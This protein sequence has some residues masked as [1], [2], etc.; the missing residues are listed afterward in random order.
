MGMSCIYSLG[1]LFAT[2]ADGVHTLANRLNGVVK[3][4]AGSAA[5][6]W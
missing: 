4:I 5:C 1:I 6:I 3:E 2:E